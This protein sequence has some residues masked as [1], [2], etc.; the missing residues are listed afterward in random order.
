VTQPVIMWFRQDLRLGDHPALTAAAAAGPVIPVYVLDDVTPGDWCW[1]G[2]SRW[3]LHHSLAALRQKVPLVLRRGESV[4]ALE[5]LVGETKPQG[6]YFTRDYAPWSGALERRVKELCDRSGVS[7]HRHGGY[8]LHEPESIRTGSGSWFKVY[9][10]FSR[11]C[12]A[13]GTPRPAKPAAKPAW[14][15]AMP[16][17]EKLET[18]NLLPTRPNWA[19][20]FEA[21]WTPGEDGAKQRLAHFLEKRPE[22]LCQLARPARPHACVKAFAASALG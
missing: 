9:T 3:W 1:G 6:L 12:F 13:T 15:D 18:W 8:L 4:A 17:S 16:H 2:A 10:P 21:Q 7:C 20:G 22:R 11:A 5:K 19:T 14:H